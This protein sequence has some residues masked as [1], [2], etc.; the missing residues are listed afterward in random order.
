M[1]KPNPNLDAVQDDIRK[2][3]ESGDE[4]SKASKV[5][6]QNTWASSAWDE[7][8]RQV[9]ASDVR[10]ERV[11][12]GWQ[13]RIPIGMVSLL[14]GQGGLGKSLELV[15]LAAGWSRGTIPGDFYGQPISVAIAS[16]EDHRAAV[17]VPRLIAA[18]AD[19]SRVT[20]PELVDKDGVSSDIAIDGRFA[21]IER[22]FVEAGVKVLL[23]DTV[24]AHM[25][26]EH[27]SYKEQDVRAALKPLAQMAE[28]CGIVVVGTMHLNRREARD[29]LTRIS[30]SGAFGNL[31]RSVLVFAADP[32]EPDG[33]TRI[34]AVGK[35]NVGVKPPAIRLRIESS[36]VPTDDGQQ[37]PTPRMVVV[38]DT[39]HST[40]DL[41]GTPA[42]DGER[43]AMDEAVAFLR[44]L[45]AEGPVATKQ[46]KAEA[47]DAGVAVITL[48]RA[49]E[50]LG[51][52]PR[53][54]GMDAGWVWELP[55]EQEAIASEREDVHRMSTFEDAHE[56][57]KMLIQNTWASS[58][59][60]EHLRGEDRWQAELAL[61]DDDFDA[62][63]A[64]VSLAEY[65]PTDDEAFRAQ[66][67]NEA[68]KD[69]VDLVALAREIFPGSWVS[70]VRPAIGLARGSQ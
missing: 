6:I 47:R 17:V 57:S 27:D 52:H 19:L 2:T 69:A 53:K 45:L 24:I 59:W 10:P 16:A 21:V 22:G 65:Q 55:A 68:E 61:D 1:Q 70:G 43:T 39:A 11:A 12:W 48:R 40:S 34:L 15:T 20:F 13:D 41:L 49:Q 44:D 33:S 58:A 36:L 4:P 26:R 37:I 30:G 8:L 18:G 64:F 67:T 56:E 51:I 62:D 14:V 38:G 54:L 25:T 60:D 29:I 32:D 28:R 42:D 63:A 9:L 66:K 3:F 35:T 7:H 46:V 23:I 31:A 5:S 50:R